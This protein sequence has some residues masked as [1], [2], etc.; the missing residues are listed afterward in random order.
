MGRVQFQVGGVDFVRLVLPSKQR[1][2]RDL[3]VGKA[4]LRVAGLNCSPEVTITRSSL[5]RFFEQINEAHRVLNGSFVLEST[6]SRFRLKGAVNRKGAFQF[7]VV[8]TGLRLTQPE[9]TEW[10]ATASF[11]CNS[12]DLQEAALAL[13]NEES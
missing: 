7:D 13:E 8:C 2:N 10:S 11:T 6:D 1:G 4:V 12:F 3:F 5:L 9:N